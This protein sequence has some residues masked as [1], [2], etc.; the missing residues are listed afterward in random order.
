MSKT[1][2]KPAASRMDAV[3]IRKSCQQQDVDG[4]KANVANMLRSLKANVPEVNWFV[5]T[6]SRRKV[7][8]NAEFLRLMEMV[9]AGKVGTA[10]VESQDRW[11]TSDRVELFTLLGTLRNHATRLFD[12][13]A[14]KDLTEKDFA[15]ELLAVIQSFKSEKELQDLAYR[16]LRTRVANF[17]DTGSWPTGTHPFG[18]GKRCYSTDG[19]LLWEW[20]PLSRSRGQAFYPDAAGK[21]VPSGP[22]IAAIPRKAKGEKAKTVLVPS[23]NPKSV[24]AFKLIFDLYTRIGLSRRQISAHL[25]AG[26]DLQRRA[27][28]PPGHH[29]HPSEPRLRSPAATIG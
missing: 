15:T 23:N 1:N 18:Y 14:G 20:Q 9:E 28:H 4:Q 29:Q 7:G 2:G 13:R 22:D 25:N 19:K 17:K 21:L 24:K 12:L 5:G 8:G 10:Y 11:G 3:F 16:S 6:V 27:V 26:P